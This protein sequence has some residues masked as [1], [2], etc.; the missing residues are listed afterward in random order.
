MARGDLATDRLPKDGAKVIIPTKALNLI[1][2]LIDDP[3][4]MVGF[5][6]REN[7][8]IFHTAQATLTSNLIEGASRRTTT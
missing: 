4:E 8:V 1:D 6:V 7:R 2:K 3:A 5:Q